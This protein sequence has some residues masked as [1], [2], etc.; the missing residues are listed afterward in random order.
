[1]QGLVCF[2]SWGVIKLQS[3]Q[4][5]DQLDLNAIAFV[6]SSTEALSVSQIDGWNVPELQKGLR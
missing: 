3:E 1:L 6:T 2:V 5:T 4:R